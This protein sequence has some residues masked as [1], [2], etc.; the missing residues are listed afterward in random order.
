MY[1]WFQYAI[2]VVELMYSM[3]AS[4]DQRRQMHVELYGEMCALL[5]ADVSRIEDIPADMKPAITVAAKAN[6]IKLLSK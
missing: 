3:F 1:V 2:P 4:M 5:S 6:I